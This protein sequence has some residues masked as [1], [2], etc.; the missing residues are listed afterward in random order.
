M[1]EGFIAAS[2]THREPAEVDVLVDGEPLHATAGGHVT[3]LH[4]VQEERSGSAPREILELVSPFE[5]VR[6]RIK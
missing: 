6:K 4:P 1:V 5:L 2:P 3:H